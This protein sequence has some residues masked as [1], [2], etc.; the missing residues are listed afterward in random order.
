ME[1]LKVELYDATACLSCDLNY[2]GAP[3]TCTDDKKRY[4]GKLRD[5]LAVTEKIVESARRRFYQGRDM[6]DCSLCLAID[7][8]DALKG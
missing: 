3:C 5:R 1:R 8:L 7:E 4:V 2:S 6:C